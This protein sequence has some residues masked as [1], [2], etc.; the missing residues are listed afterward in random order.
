[1]NSF[2][3]LLLVIVLTTGGALILFS[4]TQSKLVPWANSHTLVFD[5]ANCDAGWDGVQFPLMISFTPW[6]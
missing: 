4:Q 2:T 3:R 5:R 1:M 6:L